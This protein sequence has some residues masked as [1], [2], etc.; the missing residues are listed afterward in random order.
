MQDDT[1]GVSVC[2]YKS[3][4]MNNFLNTTTQIM[5]LQFGSESVRSYTLGKSM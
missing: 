5:G 1:L 2:G 3:K 4:K